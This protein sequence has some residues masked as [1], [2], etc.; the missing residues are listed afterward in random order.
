MKASGFLHAITFHAITITR[1]KVDVV[2]GYGMLKKCYW[3][4][5]ACYLNSYV[6]YSVAQVN[7]REHLH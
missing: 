3:V 4:I 2:G 5:V 1:L 6:A 7:S